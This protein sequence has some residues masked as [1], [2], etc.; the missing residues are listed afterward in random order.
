MTDF[1]D[2]RVYEDRA[3][4]ATLKRAKNARLR[5]KIRSVARCVLESDGTFDD[6][7]KRLSELPNG[8]LWPKSTLFKYLQDP[9]VH[10]EVDRLSDQLDLVSIA[11]KERTIQE[12]VRHGLVTHGNYI[13]STGEPKSMSELTEDEAACVKTTKMVKVKVLEKDFDG[14][15]IEVEKSIVYPDELWDKIKP[16]EMLAKMHKLLVDKVEKSGEVK[17]RLIT[18]VDDDD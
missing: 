13:H 15:S 4:W 10:R 7:R 12:I 6:I 1:N 2:P 16:L 9:K 11:N 5:A 18:N 3:K 17:V 8:R 14:N